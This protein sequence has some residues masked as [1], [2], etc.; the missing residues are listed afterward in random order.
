MKNAISEIIN[1]TK[2]NLIIRL[3]LLLIFVE[4]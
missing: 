3:Q 1:S 4:S 2:N